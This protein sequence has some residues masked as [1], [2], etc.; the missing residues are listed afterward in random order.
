MQGIFALSFHPALFQMLTGKALG[1]MLSVAVRSNLIDGQERS[2]AGCK[3]SM[4][5]SAHEHSS[6]GMMQLWQCML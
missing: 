2:R 5:V 3:V 6:T 4:P 1:F